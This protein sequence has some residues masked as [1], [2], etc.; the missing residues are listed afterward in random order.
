M[1]YVCSTSPEALLAE[2]QRQLSALAEL[3][4]AMAEG[5][6]AATL[7]T[8]DTTDKLRLADAFTKVGRCLRMSIALSMRLSRGEPIASAREGR[9]LEAEAE[10]EAERDD[11]DVLEDRPERLEHENLYDRLPAGDLATQIA[12]V[13][14]TLAG[15]ARTLPAPV[16][17]ACRARC[18]AIAAETAA[19]VRPPHELRERV[20]QAIPAATDHAPVRARGPPR[21]N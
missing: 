21:L 2:Q 14:R 16:A 17:T 10:V 13:A 15:V 4:L 18:E 8:D 9:D 12:T 19:L 11:S 1:F 3:S 7:A 6:Q 20:E 5:L